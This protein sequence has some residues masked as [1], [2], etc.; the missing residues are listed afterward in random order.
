VDDN[1]RTDVAEA[2]RQIRELTGKT[3][4]ELFGERLVDD[5]AWMP[6][7]VAHRCG[8]IEGVAQALNATVLELLDELDI[9]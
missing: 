3:A 6:S 2:L 8:F 9:N 4:D 7:I 5:L 1:L